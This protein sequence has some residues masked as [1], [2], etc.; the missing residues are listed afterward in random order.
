MTMYE[1]Y[2]LAYN[3][4]HKL[5]DMYKKYSLKYCDP[6]KYLKA[7]QAIIPNAYRFKKKPFGVQCN[8]SD[9]CTEV[10]MVVNNKKEVELR[11][12]QIK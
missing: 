2:E 10:S 5:Y 1:T 8:C 9:G 3:N 4:Y 7:I 6:D 11:Y 12:K